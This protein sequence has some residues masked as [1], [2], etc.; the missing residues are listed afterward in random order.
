MFS[1]VTK[2]LKNVRYDHEFGKLYFNIFNKAIAVLV[3]LGDN[4]LDSCY[5]IARGIIEL[6][7]KLLILK[8]NSSLIHEHNSLVELER[9][10][11]CYGKNFD[12]IFNEK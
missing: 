3:L 1:I 6:Y 7:L 12:E 10:I 11:N 8:F 2:A 4:L 5:P 9:K